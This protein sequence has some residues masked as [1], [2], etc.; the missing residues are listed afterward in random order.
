MR[1]PLTGSRSGWGNTG[2]S[3]AGIFIMK[4][5]YGN[6]SAMGGDP[7]EGDMIDSIGL[8]QNVKAAR[9]IDV[10]IRGN[11]GRRGVLFNGN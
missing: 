10:F 7:T 8:K 3:G 4:H 2:K 9:E 5:F 1:D 6:H 11:A